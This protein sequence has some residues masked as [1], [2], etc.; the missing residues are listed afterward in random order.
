MPILCTSLFDFLPLDLLCCSTLT[1]SIDPCLRCLDN[2]V[3]CDLWRKT[4]F[5][6]GYTNE[7]ISSF[8]RE[9]INL[10]ILGTYCACSRAILV[11]QSHNEHLWK[12]NSRHCQEASLF[13]DKVVRN[14]FNSF[15]WAS[16]TYM[17]HCGSTPREC[18][19][20]CH[21][22]VPWNLS[23]L[24]K[25]PYNNRLHNVKA[26]SCGRELALYVHWDTHF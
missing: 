8:P 13:S 26:D 11:I 4:T 21:M 24:H 6:Y 23:A 18:H 17:I 3:L 25:P 20:F 1:A 2:C 15:R 9:R 16:W 22:V 7:S 14:Y 12:M 19:I 5:C 10:I